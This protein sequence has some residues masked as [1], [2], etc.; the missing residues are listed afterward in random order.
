MSYK[1]SADSGRAPDA[2]AWIEQFCLSPW[3]RAGRWLV[4]PDSHSTHIWLISES[5]D[6]PPWS[7]A[8]TE[9]VCPLC[10][11]PLAG[12]GEGLGEIDGEMPATIVS[13]IRALDRAA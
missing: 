5:P 13:F 8:C 4:R 12:H 2:P 6:A 7:V 11:E 9:P 3:C 10:G 1:H